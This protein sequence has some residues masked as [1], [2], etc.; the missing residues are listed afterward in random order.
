MVL[1]KEIKNLQK[2]LI[3]SLNTIVFVYSW[4][5]LLNIS[6]FYIMTALHCTS[7]TNS[8]CSFRTRYNLQSREEKSHFYTQ[9]SSIPHISNKQHF[10]PDKRIIYC[11]FHYILKNKEFTK[12]ITFWFFFRKYS[13]I[14]FKIKNDIC[15]LHFSF[16]I[17][18]RKWWKL[19]SPRIC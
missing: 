16:H 4:I 7:F 2:E 19:L 6:S 3:H 10:L 13:D 15:V 1:R 5:F 12:F 8:R 11:F 9:G 14:M 17:S 18:T